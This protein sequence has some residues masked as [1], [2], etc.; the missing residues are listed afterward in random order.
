MKTRSVAI[1]V[2]CGL[3]GAAFVLAQ[4]LPTKVPEKLPTAVTN[5]H[6][7]MEI[8]YEP[9][10]ERLKKDMAAQP[11]E[12]RGWSRIKHDAVG[13]AELANL[14]AIRE[15]KDQAKQAKWLELARG[16]QQA[17][18]DLAAAANAKDWTKTQSAYQ[19]VVA[20]C[21]ACHQASGSEHAPEIEP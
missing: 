21:N 19:A 16:S 12:R 13:V 3:F 9:T 1:L 11:T 10:F 20:N 14:A 6:E 17:G 7:L 18:L 8:L 4:D 15:V 5:T 2:A